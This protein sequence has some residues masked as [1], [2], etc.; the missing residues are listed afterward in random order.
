MQKERANYINIPKTVRA[1]RDKN[2]LKIKPNLSEK[3]NGRNKN[4]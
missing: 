3:F 4:V 2:A 1:L